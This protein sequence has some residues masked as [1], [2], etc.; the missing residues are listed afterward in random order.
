MNYQDLINTMNVPLP[1]RVKRITSASAVISVNGT[2]ISGTTVRLDVSDHVVHVDLNDSD[3]CTIELPAVAA[4]EGHKYLIRNEDFGGGLT[5]ADQD[6]S[7][8]WTDL[9]TDADNE[10]VLLEA[11]GNQWLATKTDIA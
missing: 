11:R 5:I 2:A 3:T 7:T 8:E 9:T 10:Y 1:S 4:A 6:D